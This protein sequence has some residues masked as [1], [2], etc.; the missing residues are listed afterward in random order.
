MNSDG[1]EIVDINSEDVINK[2]KDKN[3]TNLIPDLQIKISTPL[4]ENVDSDQKVKMTV[5]FI[6]DTLAPDIEADRKFIK[7]K[8]DIDEM[9][10][11]YICDIC[12]AKYQNL[13]EMNSKLCID[14]N[15]YYDY[16]KIH[17]TITQCPFCSYYIN[18]NFKE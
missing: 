10:I 8:F 17:E 12:N 16:C 3:I 9:E 6:R 18:A 1:V 7:D 2:D 13:N 5:K 4:D 14:C 15:K 11:T